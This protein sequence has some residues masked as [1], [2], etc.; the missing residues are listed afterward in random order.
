MRCRI[1][2]VIDAICKKI[3]CQ[4]TA[5]QFTGRTAVLFTTGY[6]FIVLW[7]RWTVWCLDQQSNSSGPFDPHY[8]Q[9][10]DYYTYARLSS[11]VHHYVTVRTVAQVTEWRGGG[12]KTVPV[13]SRLGTVEVVVVVVSIRRVLIVRG[14]ATVWKFDTPI[15]I[16]ER[17]L[18]QEQCHAM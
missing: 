17:L 2:Q 14:A 16:F 7:T 8:L 13:S 15:G 9:W 4:T 5:V 12:E 18:A 1:S 6:K 10:V 11:V 3:W